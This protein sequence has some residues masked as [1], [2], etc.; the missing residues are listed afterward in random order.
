MSYWQERIVQLFEKNTYSVVNIFDVTLR[1]QLNVTGMVEVLQHH[2][3][4]FFHSLKQAKSD[5]AMMSS[6]Y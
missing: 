3:L 6:A 5:V 4:I 2:N 1:P